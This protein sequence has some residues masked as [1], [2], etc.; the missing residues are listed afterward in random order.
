MSQLPRLPQRGRGR[1]REPA[2]TSEQ[3]DAGTLIALV[4]VIAVSAGFLGLTAMVFPQLLVVVAL[5]A[6]AGLFFVLHYVTWGRALSRIRD[7]HGFDDTPRPVPPVVSGLPPEL[8]E[9]PDAEEDED[10]GAGS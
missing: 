7:E 8:L 10:E 4:A 6:G 5:M 1:E 9:E 3:R 2:V